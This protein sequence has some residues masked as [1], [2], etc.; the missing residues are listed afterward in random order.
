MNAAFS[1]NLTAVATTTVKGFRPH[2]RCKFIHHSDYK[3]FNLNMFYQVKNWVVASVAV[4]GV[5]GNVLSF[6]ILRKEISKNTSI[7]YL[8]YLAILDVC[9]CASYLV[10]DFQN[11]LYSH[12]LLL[13]HTLQFNHFMKRLYP[14][15]QQ[16][17]FCFSGVSDM[18][19]LVIAVDRF[20]VVRWPL[21]ASTLISMKRAHINVV[22]I[23]LLVE[24][25]CVQLFFKRW[26]RRSINPCTGYER[27]TTRITA[28]SKNLYYRYYMLFVHAPIFHM[29]PSVAIFMI[30]INIIVIL[31][32]SSDTRKHMTSSTVPSRNKQDRSLTISLV[33]ICSIHLIKRSLLLSGAISNWLVYKYGKKALL[34]PGK[35]PYMDGVKDLMRK[36]SASANFFIYV[37][38][39]ESFRHRLRKMCFVIRTNGSD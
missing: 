31:K 9:M 8:K 25:T 30:T 33:I 1:V 20:I 3:S 39:R 2:S 18:L 21:K 34:L 36:V 4:F 6:V 22:A 13:D 12:T 7:F 28:F 5:I 17:R 26:T 23:T 27:W 19:I 32:S 16:I 29:I 24:V 37:A 11:E 35:A 38:M 10:F 14:Y 15:T